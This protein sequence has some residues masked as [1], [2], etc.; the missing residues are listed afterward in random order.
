MP[1]HDSLWGVR[2]MNALDVVLFPH[3]KRRGIKTVYWVLNTPEDVR[4]AMRSGVD[5]VMTDRPAM[6]QE[7]VEQAKKAK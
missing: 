5:C 4:A 1:E 7:V 3:L 2:L 6:M